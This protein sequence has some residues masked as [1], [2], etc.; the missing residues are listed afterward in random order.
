MSDAF[1]QPYLWEGNDIDFSGYS[2]VAIICTANASVAWTVN[3]VV[4]GTAVALPL[5]YS[6][7]ATTTQQTTAQNTGV[8]YLPIGGIIRLT[9]GTGG[10]F[11]LRGTSLP[12]GLTPQSTT[13][14]AIAAGTNAIGDVGTQ[15]R[16]NA[17]GA[18]SQVSVM[19]TV[20]PTA[21]SVKASA[22]RLLGFVLQN[23]SAAIRSVKFWNTAVGGVTLGTTAAIWEVDIPAGQS[24]TFEMEGG[25]AFST[26]ITYAVTGAKGLTDNTGALGAN[27]VSGVILFA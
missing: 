26:A 20:T 27:D 21:T 14:P 8:Y 25:M 5:W 23:S 16:A 4:N 3:V 17:T 24:L 15:Y 1:S 6:T 10:T 2:Q 9:G 13:T 18:A 22:G 7:G 11:W 12:M 19:S